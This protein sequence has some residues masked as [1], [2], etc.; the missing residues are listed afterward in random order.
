MAK[1][2]QTRYAAALLALG[3]AEQK[4]TAHFRVFRGY[5]A[6]L[7]GATPIDRSYYL[8]KSGA[9]RWSDKHKVTQARPCSPKTG[10][11]LLALMPEPPPRGTPKNAALGDL[12]L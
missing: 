9:L 11:R 6:A 12:D 5:S 10:E 4:P 1:I 8:G 7:N 2:L 3:F